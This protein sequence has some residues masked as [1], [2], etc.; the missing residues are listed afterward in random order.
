MAR[1]SRIAQSIQMIFCRTK[2]APYP[3]RPRKKGRIVRKV[4]LV[5][6]FPFCA[7]FT[8]ITVPSLLLRG[9][10]TLHSL[11]TLQ[12]YYAD[13]G[14]FITVTGEI[15]HVGYDEEDNM[16]YLG[17]INCSERFS[18]YS[19]RI[20]SEN[21]EVIRQNG[22]MELIEEGQTITFVTAPGYFGD[23]YHMPIVALSVG[24]VV[25][26][27]FEEGYTNFWEWLTDY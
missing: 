26:L 20:V 11:I 6:I 19:F 25:L 15:Y 17:M 21:V 16:L 10:G 7:L 1:F 3:S 4:L 24:E 2:E 23:G 9:I 14:H 27:E 12:P 13:T 8:I 22:G 18:D 5:L